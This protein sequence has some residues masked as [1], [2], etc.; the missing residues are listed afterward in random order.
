M[1]RTPIILVYALN[2]LLSK[3]SFLNFG[4]NK[5]V[6]TRIIQVRKTNFYENPVSVTNFGLKSHFGV[7]TR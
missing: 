2:T 3:K 7:F 6:L 5:Y 1:R 4:S